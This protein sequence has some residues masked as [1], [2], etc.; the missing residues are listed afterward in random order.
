MIKPRMGT[1][2]TEGCNIT[3]FEQ[4]FPPYKP[5]KIFLKQQIDMTFPGAY[6]LQAAAP[7]ATPVSQCS[8]SCRLHRQSASSRKILNDA[9]AEDSLG[10]RQP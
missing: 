10:S 3:E 6:R 5:A 9:C 4:I 1:I 8:C 7:D 2:C